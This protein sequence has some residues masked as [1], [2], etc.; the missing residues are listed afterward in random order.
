L[1][2]AD[3]ETE[4]IIVPAPFLSERGHGIPHRNRECNGALGWVR[5]W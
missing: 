5:A 4:L 2:N 1:R 3:A